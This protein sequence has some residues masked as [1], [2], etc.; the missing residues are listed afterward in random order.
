MTQYGHVPGAL[1][2]HSTF[3]DSQ[4]ILYAIRDAPRGYD[5]II[6]SEVKWLV[7]QINR[8]IQRRRADPT[9]KG[10]KRL[11]NEWETPIIDLIE[12]RTK[13]GD[14]F[15]DIVYSGK[16]VNSKRGFTQAKG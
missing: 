7:A 12:F 5:L 9:I 14:C 8:A 3:P 1:H 11:E 16:D 2:A 4:G 6:E 13:R 10:K 15:V